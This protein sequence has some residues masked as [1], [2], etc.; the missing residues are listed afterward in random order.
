M[1]AWL[2]FRTAELDHVDDQIALRAVLPCATC[3]APCSSKDEL[4]TFCDECLSASDLRSYP[5]DWVM[6]GGWD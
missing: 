4:V 2:T 1:S 6:L 3:G 5:E